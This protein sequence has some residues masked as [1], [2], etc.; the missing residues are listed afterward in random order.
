[1]NA[2]TEKLQLKDW[3]QKLNQLK[4]DL[5]LWSNEVKSTVAIMVSQPKIEVDKLLKETLQKL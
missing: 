2:G 5:Y 1:M 4:T 3:R